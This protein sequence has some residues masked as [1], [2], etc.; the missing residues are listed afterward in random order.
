M[1]RYGWSVHTAIV[2]SAVVLFMAIATAAEWPWWEYAFLSDG[3][4]VAW[5]SGALL[6]A[7][8]AVA[9]NLTITR[10]L[11][12]GLGY[13]LSIAIALLALDE[14]F[15]LHERVKAYTSAGDLPTFAV[16]VGGVVF[17]AALAKSIRS[18]AAR[19][20]IAGAILTGLFALWVDL[21]RPPA[22]IARL[23]EAF[24]VI[25]EGLFLCGLIEVARS[26]V[27]SAD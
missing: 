6:A 8:A 13:V 22:T 18:G 15:Q 11:P 2:L 19:G 24:E 3:S 16:G 10:A 25:A 20:L 1:T 7:N 4:P 23:E 27:Q 17:A 9:L 26:Q 5:L 14:Q 12:R 21:G